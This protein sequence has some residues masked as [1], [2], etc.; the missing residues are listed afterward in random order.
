M[1]KYIIAFRFKFFSSQRQSMETEVINR[2]YYPIILE[3]SQCCP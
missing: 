3:N 1:N 2:D